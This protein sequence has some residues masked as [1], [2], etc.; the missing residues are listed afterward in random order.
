M[1]KSYILIRYSLLY[2]LFLIGTFSLVTVVVVTNSSSSVTPLFNVAFETSDRIDGTYRNINQGAPVFAFNELLPPTAEP[3]EAFIKISNLSNSTLAY[4][5]GFNVTQ[6]SLASAVRLDIRDVNDDRF[7]TFTGQALSTLNIA[8]PPLISNDFDI[9]QV[10][11]RLDTQVLT[12]EFN[13]ESDDPRFP[14]SFSFDL[15][16]FVF[17]IA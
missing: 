6:D 8:G 10:L 9:Y 1:N 15:S 5:L 13:L 11:L 16:L 17:E 14:L 4:R 2:I 12:N 7:N 3:L